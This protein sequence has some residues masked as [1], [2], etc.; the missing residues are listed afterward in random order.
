MIRDDLLKP[1]RVPWIVVHEPMSAGAPWIV[2]RPGANP[3]RVSADIGTLLSELDGKR[4]APDLAAALGTRWTADAVDGAVR[5]LDE[6]GLI[7]GPTSVE[8]KPERRVEL[9]SPTRL[10][11]RLVQATRLL[12]PLRPW[13][14]KLSGSLV[15]TAVLVLSLGGILALSVQWPALDQALG[16]PLP[17]ASVLLIWAGIILTTVI[18]ELGHGATLTHFHGRPG[19]LGVMLFYLTPACFCEVTDSWRLAHR[20]QRVAVALAGVAVQTSVAG[21]AAVVALAVP[22]GDIRS[23]VIGFAVVCYITGLINLIPFVKLDGYL[24][25]MAH[26]DSPRLRDRAIADAQGW[27]AGWMLGTRRERE[28]RQ[29]WAVPFG[30]MCMSF[31]VV[32]VLFAAGRWG[33]LLLSVGAIGGA[34]L[35]LLF[36]AL[37]YWLVRA[38][39]RWTRRAR[40]AG[41]GWPRLIAVLTL[42]ALALTVPLAFIKA[43][44]EV[45]GGYVSDNTGVYFVL[46]VGTDLS[47]VRPGD[48]VVLRRGGLMFGT[49]LG[50]GVID[51]GPTRKKVPLSALMPFQSDIQA[52]AVVVPVEGA[53][54]G[55]AR[56]GSAYVAG[57]RVPLG[58]WLAGNY[59]TPAWHQIFGQEVPQ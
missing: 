43:R 30:L 29:R 31:P 45:R 32:I 38:V 58:Q 37:A 13:L 6:L 15:L 3:L 21:L 42:A 5:K 2:E 34:V 4:N 7:E 19:W 40:Q 14:T 18:H 56:T 28:L 46:P 20:R 27:L 22:F 52:D 9:V 12:D 41:V 57:E 36:C 1:R 24:A 47:A 39:V 48:G 59:L 55:L 50:T 11:F 10:Q 35:L 17:L 23:T 25:L 44:N 26:L 16:A 33:H 51:N 53:P 8:P 54:G 49:D